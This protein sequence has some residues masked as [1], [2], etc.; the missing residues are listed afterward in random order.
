[1]R[2]S[3]FASL[4]IPNSKEKK[5]FEKIKNAEKVGTDPA[6]ENLCQHC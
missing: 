5:M 3:T 6:L 2:I 4:Q 1:M